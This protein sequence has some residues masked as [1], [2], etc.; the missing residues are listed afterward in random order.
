MATL[1]IDKAPAPATRTVEIES[2]NRC[3]HFHGEVT[4]S[5]NKDGCTGQCRLYEHNSFVSH[6][7]GVCGKSW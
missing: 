3:N 5:D 7:C 1:V 4:G 6:V 2:R